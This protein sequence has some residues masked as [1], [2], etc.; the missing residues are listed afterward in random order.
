M[1][2]HRVVITGIGA[3]TPLGLTATSSF[4]NLLN[5]LNGIH[6]ILSLPEWR[7]LHREI[8][9]LSSHLAAP[10]LGFPPHKSSLA[11]R[12]KL[13]RNFRFSEMAA[14]EALID[15]ALSEEFYE[16]V[17]VFL[18]CAMPAISETYENSTLISE[19]V[20][21]TCLNYPNC[22]LIL[23]SLEENIAVLYPSR[24]REFSR[25]SYFP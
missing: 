14:S 7:H 10:V 24:P 17:G 16:N 18:G 20:K 11:E 12:I 1:T 25:K 21:T 2:F 6:N 15:S 5:G 22:P 8:R 9:S 3:V 23:P 19:N 13:P 4:Q